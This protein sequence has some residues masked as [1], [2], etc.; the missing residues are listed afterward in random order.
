MSALYGFSLL[1]IISNEYRQIHGCSSIQPDTP[2][3]NLGVKLAL[4]Q[5]PQLN[6]PPDTVPE[7]ERA[8]NKKLSDLC[9]P[10]K[11]KIITRVVFH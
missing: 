11:N 6:Y 4:R 5:P 1:L 7:P 10:G 2:P 9:G 3:A 8:D